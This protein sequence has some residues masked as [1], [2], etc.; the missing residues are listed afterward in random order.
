[1]ITSTQ[2]LVLNKRNYG[3]TS[4][5]CNL[6]SIDYGKIA[7]IA[8]GARSIKNPLG[9][10]LQPLNQ[11]ECIYYYKSSRNIQ[12]LKEAAIIEKYF[13]L[14]NN[15]TKM[16]YALT[17]ADIVN[18][19]NYVDYPS[20]I[21][22]RLTKKTLQSINT[23]NVQDLDILFVFFQLQCLIYLGYQP[24]IYNCAKCS[25]I[26]KSAIFDFSIGQL[27]C[28]K[29]SNYKLKLDYES[30]KIIDYLMKTHN[31]IYNPFQYILLPIN[32]KKNIND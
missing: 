13:K 8:K 16:N 2:A 12:I 28:T 4:L 27:T 18:H 32:N 30:L 11:I 1:M 14:E 24:S 23:S 22:F 29:C 19:I 26:L 3:D 31:F 21:I 17:I 7:I 15:Y 6:F 20:K 25:T 10:A 5:I 9:A